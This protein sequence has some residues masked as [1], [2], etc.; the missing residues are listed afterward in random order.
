M[1]YHAR[2]GLASRMLALYAIGRLRD[3]LYRFYSK[4][5][6]LIVN[7]A[8]TSLYEAFNARGQSRGRIR[9]VQRGN[10]GGTHYGLNATPL[11]TFYCVKSSFTYRQL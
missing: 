1:V 9:D 6:R 10:R 5:S 4:V 7:E 2:D 8:T 11:V 3:Q